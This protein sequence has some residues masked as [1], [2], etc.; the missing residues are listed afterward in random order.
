MTA[1]FLIQA[2]SNSKRLP[3]KI[4]RE[5]GEKP[6]LLHIID[7]IGKITGNYKVQIYILC[8]EQDQST[9][10][11]C[12]QNN[13]K[14][15]TGEEKNVFSR[16]LAYAKTVNKNDLGIRLTGDNPF[17]DFK[18][19]QAMLDDFSDEED[20]MYPDFLPLG[21]GAEVFRISSLLKLDGKILSPH[22]REHVT[23]FFREYSEL[24]KIKVFQT[25]FPVSVRDVRITIDEEVDLML[26]RKL[27]HHFENENPFF[28]TEEI[29]QLQ[30]TDA[31]LFHLNS[32]V[33]QKSH[34]S[35]EK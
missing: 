5:I 10:Q 34:L 35:Y 21:A 25:K 24:F 3:G 1:H 19:T 31:N 8:P 30:K 20:Y 7:R 9:I 27:F 29:Y 17:L 14:F 12:R 13:L 23:V 32:N 33:I 2:R 22:H 4:F 26:A 11:F 6:L 28:T 15:F 16:Y 18:I